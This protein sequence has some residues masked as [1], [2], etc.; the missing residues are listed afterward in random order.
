MG[1]SQSHTWKSSFPFLL[2]KNPTSNPKTLCLCLCLSHMSNSRSS[3]LKHNQKPIWYVCS[4]CG[5]RK[6]AVCWQFCDTLLTPVSAAA[7]AY[8]YFQVSIAKIEKFP[9]P[10]SQISHQKH[11]RKEKRESKYSVIDVDKAHT[12]LPLSV[13]LSFLQTTTKHSGKCERRNL[14]VSLNLAEG[15]FVSVLLKICSYFWR[16]ATCLLILDLDPAVRSCHGWIWS[17]GLL[18]AGEIWTTWKWCLE[19]RRCRISWWNPCPTLLK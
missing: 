12:S 14:P 9:Q 4:S 15:V 19:G 8:Y 11:P 5:E 17:V 18:D 7:V 10:K 16:G 6:K 2:Q 1:L 3:R 13:S